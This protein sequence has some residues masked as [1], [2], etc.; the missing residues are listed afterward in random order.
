MNDLYWDAEIYKSYPCELEMPEHL[1]VYGKLVD[2]S[3]AHPNTFNQFCGRLRV[4][5]VED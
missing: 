3:G 5:G 4:C 2:T 1:T